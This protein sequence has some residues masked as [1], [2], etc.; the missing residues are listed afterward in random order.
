MASDAG[1][2]MGVGWGGLTGWE[3]ST[4]RTLVKFS[5]S[6]VLFPSYLGLLRFC[7]QS[8]SGLT[9]GAL[10]KFVFWQKLNECHAVVTG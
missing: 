3:N 5:N 9:P 1:P 6:S 8:G 2:Q 10:Q 7:F 4:Y